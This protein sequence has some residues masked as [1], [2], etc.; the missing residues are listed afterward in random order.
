[1]SVPPRNIAIIGGGIGGVATAVALDRLGIKATVYEQTP[2]LREVGAG[3]MLWPN[4][5]RVLRELGLLS[6]I[7]DR[8]GANTHF[9][10]RAS[11]GKILMNIALGSFDVPALCTRR[12]DLLAVLLAQLPPER[13]RLGHTLT[14]L[15]QSDSSMRLGFAISMGERHIEQSVEHDAVIGADGLRSR[16]REE[17]FGPSEPVYRGYTVWRGVATYDGTG[18]LRGSNSETW[19]RGKRFGILNTGED[20]FT[21]YAAVNVGEDHADAPE[22]R[23]QELLEMFAGWHEPISDLI[24]ATDETVI[25]KNGAF[26]RAPLSRWTRGRITLLGDAAHPCTPNLGQGCCMALE[27]ALVLAKCVARFPSIANAFER[28]ESLR[29]PRASHMQHRSLTMGWIGQWDNRLLVAG[30]KAVTSL[31]P[32]RLFEYNLRRVYSYET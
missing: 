25:L 4:A 9:L 12:A 6:G 18:I 2:E 29:R 7:I 19:G 14:D 31:L 8:S 24:R 15:D 27:D 1:V 22:G 10:V 13:I 23:K 21:W 26:D 16:V 11:S 30:R 3:L 28:Y 17:L 5:T 32:A 20:R